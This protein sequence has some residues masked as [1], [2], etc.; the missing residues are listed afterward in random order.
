MKKYTILFIAA[1]MV[2][3]TVSVFA[4]QGG[5]TGPSAFTGQQTGFTGQ[6]AAFTGQTGFFGPAM[7]VTVQQVVQTFPNKAE[8]ILRGNIVQHLGGDRYL[9]RDASGDIV[10]K[11]KHDRWWGLSVGPNDRVEIGGK[12]K[13]EKNGWIKY[14]DGKNIRRV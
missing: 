14:F 3:S 9:F 11:I 6:Q 10:I 8:A 4:Q 12:L 2:I 13:R 5:F 1:L 7:N